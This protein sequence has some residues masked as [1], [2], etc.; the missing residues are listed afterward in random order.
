MRRN[1][2]KTQ[3]FLKVPKGDKTQTGECTSSDSTFAQR[4]HRENT[5][6][7]VNRRECRLVGQIIKND[8]DYK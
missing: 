4:C 8:N 1:F 2:V 6:A 7:E 5:S 3:N